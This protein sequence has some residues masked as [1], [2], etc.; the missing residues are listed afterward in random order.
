MRP[1][2]VR[3]T[4]RRTDGKPFGMNPYGGYQLHQVQ[5]TKPAPRSLPTSHGADARRR[6]SFVAVAR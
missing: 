1:L 2:V 3:V 4:Q 6:R 5:R